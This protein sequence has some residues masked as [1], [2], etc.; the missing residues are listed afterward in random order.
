MWW[1]KNKWKVIVP[2][3]IIATLAAAFCFGGSAPDSDNRTSAATPEPSGA[4]STI[5]S[6]QTPAPDGDG[7]ENGM[8]MDG[9][10]GKDEYLTD[11]VPSDKPA[12]VEPQEADKGG[13]SYSW[14]LKPVTVTFTEGESVFDVLRR[15]CRDNGIHMEFKSTPAYNS[16]Y[17]E[18]IGNLYEFDAGELSGWMYSVNG[19]FPNYGC[20]RYQL[21]SGDVYAGSILLTGAPTAAIP[22]RHE[23]TFGW[24]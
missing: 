12:P 24:E 19:W 7:G 20:S 13:A 3:I 21:Q 5:A 11:P 15:V 17:I 4:A 1:K 2:F 23:T 18:G 16:A 10:T 9:E 22:T 6:E 14:I 8:T